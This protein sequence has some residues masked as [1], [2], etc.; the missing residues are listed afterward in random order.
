MTNKV[1]KPSV[2]AARVHVSARATGDR[3]SAT[4]GG[5]VV[6]GSTVSNA[7]SNARRASCTSPMRCLGFFCRQ[8]RISCRMRAGT[9]AGSRCQ[10]GSTFSTFASVSERSSPSNARVPVSISNSTTPNAQM[11]ARL[12]DGPPAR[13]LG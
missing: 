2:E 8:A 10:S 12:S 5:I 3:G 4:P 1:P 13:L 6:C 9:S 7:P 11:S